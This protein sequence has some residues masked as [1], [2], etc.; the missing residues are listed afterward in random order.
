M[1]VAAPAF[2]V[3]CELGPGEPFAWVE[4]L[5]RKPGQLLVHEVAE[6]IVHEGDGS[7]IAYAAR[8]VGP[9][10]PVVGAGDF[11]RALV[12]RL[13]G[14]R[15][16]AHIQPVAVATKQAAENARLAGTLID[17]SM[18]G[19]DATAERAAIG[20]MAG[21]DVQGLIRDGRFFMAALGGTSDATAW[22]DYALE[23]PIGRSA[24]LD[25]SSRLVAVG[26]AIPPGGGA[27]GAAVTTYAL[28][29]S[30]DH[31]AEASRFF[32]RIAAA[33]A[34]RGLGPAARVQGIP[35]LDVALGHVFRGDA[36]PTEALDKTLQIVV[37]RTQHSARALAFETNDLDAAPL[38]AELLA[39]GPMHLMI[40]VTH[41]RAEGA[42]WG[43][44]VVFLVILAESQVVQTASAR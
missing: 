19:D 24:L 21:W 17:A 25:P 7:A 3:S 40:G 18:G 26:P 20:L 36:S 37:D 32:D 27:L 43:Q 5:A 6:T 34:A 11:S 39:P 12:D 15:A 29:D 33:R 16:A 22:L 9:P 28:F 31:V 23:R 10:A 4:I 13:N 1:Q 8:H 41:H 35:E 44:Y 14:V 30:P 42:A 2:A 38:P